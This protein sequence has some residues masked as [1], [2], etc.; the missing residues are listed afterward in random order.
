M[1]LLPD[2]DPLMPLPHPRAKTVGDAASGIRYR[3]VK[4][5]TNWLTLSKLHGP[6]QLPLVLPPPATQFLLPSTPPPSD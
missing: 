6:V 3:T 1:A 5:R 2:I 4:L